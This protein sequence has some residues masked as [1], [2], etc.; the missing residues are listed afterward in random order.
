MGAISI[1]T[2]AK[3]KAMAMVVDALWMSHVY[4]DF[5]K[6]KHFMLKTIDLY[7]RPVMYTVI[8]GHNEVHRRWCSTVF[9]PIIS[10]L[11]SYFWGKGSF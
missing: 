10:S 9:G 5:I 11:V 8:S 1:N 6:Q 2:D 3:K 4:Q 7:F